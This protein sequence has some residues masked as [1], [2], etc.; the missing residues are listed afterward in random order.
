MVQCYLIEGQDVA[1]LVDSCMSGG[2]DFASTV[3]GLTDKRI[4]LVITHSDFDHTGGQ[5]DFLP[6][7]IHP[8]EFERYLAKK[9]NSAQSIHA[10]WEDMIIKL[11]E[12]EIETILIPGHTP[13]SIALFD[14]R[15]GRLFV[16]DT[17]SDM[18]IF[19]FGEGR[20]VPAFIASLKKLERLTSPEG[21]L[22]P[23]VSIH[24]AHGSTTLGPE[25]ITRTR[26][27]A[28]KLLAGELEAREAPI[29]ENCKLYSFD[30]VNLLY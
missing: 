19:L 3:R 15:N 14:R 4:A 17:I 28:E 24:P 20:S 8:S 27:A 16:G 29:K 2:A 7:F 26:I 30:G 5:A 1:L 12:V 21:Q 25:W 23:L 18:W 6:A 22:G 9:G 13:G 11:G 10:L